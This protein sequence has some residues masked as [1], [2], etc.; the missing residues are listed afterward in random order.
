MAGPLESIRQTIATEN[1]I[2]PVGVEVMREV[3]GE[4]RGERVA[5][6]D[7]ASKLSDAAEEIGMSVAHRADKK[8]L[9]QREVRQGRGA[10]L[11]ALARIADYYDKLPNMPRE[12]ALKALIDQLQTFE[13]LLGEA[14]GGGG[15]SVS[16][17]DILA[18]LQKFDG[19]VTHQYAALDMA[20]EYFGTT[21]VGESFMALLEEARG[22]FE[23]GDLGRDVRAG[24][25]AAEIAEREAATLETDPGKVRDTYRQMLRESG[26]M[27]Q[28]F[29]QIAKF[30]I[31]KKFAEICEVFREIAGRDMNMTG[32]SSDPTFLHGLLTEISK[33]K[34][35]QTV[36]ESSRE[37]V[38]KTERM[39]PAA[40]RGIGSPE[41]T[42]SKLLNFAAKMAT[43]LTDARGLLGSYEKAGPQTQVVFANGLKLLHAQLPD[44]LMPSMQAR[45]QQVST[46]G[47]LL[48][49]LVA[50]EEAAYEEE[51]EEKDRDKDVRDKRKRDQE[52]S[53]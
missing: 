3:R 31:S 47:T 14:G 13:D 52:R 5:T 9:G 10:N 12:D 17:E 40:G 4:Y 19:D 2:S 21:D 1:V 36:F 34:K 48:N 41:E 28:L 16:K 15:G 20:L 32:P 49:N 11:E 44:D 50:E 51:M 46:L 6:T 8:S 18:A 7:E 23:R 26:N 27:G 42:T 43:S 35:L 22:D 29:D 53:N 25:A 39:L 24:F 37:L 38:D 45:L 30:D 33:L